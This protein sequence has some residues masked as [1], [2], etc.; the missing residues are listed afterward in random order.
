MLKSRLR[1]VFEGFI[2]PF[3]RFFPN[4]TEYG[5]FHALCETSSKGGDIKV[6]TSQCGEDL[7]IQY[8]FKCRGLLDISYLDIGAHHPYFLNNTAIFYASGSRG[9]NIEANPDLITAFNKERPNDINLNVAVSTYDGI[10]TL[11]IPQD[12][13]T[14][15]SLDSQSLDLVSE[16]IDSIQV[17]CLTLNSVIDKYMMGRCPDLLC[18]DVEG[19]E[20]S[21]L[22]QISSLRCL[23]KVI[24]A[25]TISYSLSGR[26]V[27]NNDIKNLLLA[28][29]YIVYADTN[30]NTIFV[31]EDF[32]SR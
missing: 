32:W 25:E 3:R 7:I 21:I 5:Y 30:I 16:K 20:L 17:P 23:P 27:K 8:I 12:S 28:M 14:L 31:L 6:S 24:C 4:R 11:C 9:I 18:I 19:G 1:K 15:S 22:K 13:L 10:S 26:G 2:K 29:G